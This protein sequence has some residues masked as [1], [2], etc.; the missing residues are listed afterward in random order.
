MGVG[1]VEAH[2][3]CLLD[4]CVAM[5]LGAVVCRD[6]F[7]QARVPLNQLDGL[8]RGLLDC[9]GFDLA[10]LGVAAFALH[11]ADDAML[12]AFT[13]HGVDFPMTDPSTLLNV[14]RPLA[15]HALASQP[16]AAVIGTVS[17]APPL[18]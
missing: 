7:E 14:P 13:Q 4:V 2:P 11:Q 17:L 1:E 10:D 3:G 15:D 18:A 12:G 9:S 6:G 5:E 8:G 16:A